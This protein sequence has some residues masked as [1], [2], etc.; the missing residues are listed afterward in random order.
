MVQGTRVHNIYIANVFLSIERFRVAF[1][2][3][4]NL[5]HLTKFS[6]FSSLTVHY[7]YTES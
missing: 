4:A 3:N 1:T 5:C 7:M 2:A 6:L